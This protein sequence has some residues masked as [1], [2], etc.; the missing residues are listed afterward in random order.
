[1]VQGNILTWS[2]IIVAD[3]FSI[4]IG[5]YSG[6]KFIRAYLDN[7]DVMKYQG[8]MINAFLLIIVFP[9][10]I[11]SIGLNI[12]PPQGNASIGISIQ[13][14]YL[15]SEYGNMDLPSRTVE[16]R[17]NKQNIINLGIQN[18]FNEMKTFSVDIVC[19]DTPDKCDKALDMLVPTKDDFGVEP[20]IVFELPI[21]LN[22][23]DIVPKDKYNFNITVKNQDGSVYDY[24]P[25]TIAVG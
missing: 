2:I 8:Y 21:T 16:V 13:T 7:K 12:S 3:L 11:T 18:E 25:L 1:M 20:K 4:L 23:R 10:I 24:I 19:Q 5:A 17:R 6:Y 22:I 15:G 9:I 14:D